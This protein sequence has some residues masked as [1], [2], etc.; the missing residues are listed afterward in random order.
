MQRAPDTEYIC[1]V[2][3]GRH[4]SLLCII[5]TCHRWFSCSRFAGYARTISAE[6]IC[7]VMWHEIDVNGNGGTGFFLLCI[8]AHRWTYMVAQCDASGRILATTA[9]ATIYGHRDLDRLSA[10]N[11]LFMLSYTPR[12][13]K[14]PLFC[15]SLQTK[16]N[17]AINQQFIISLI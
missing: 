6:C 15:G 10:V 2:I 12:G 4:S 13:C 11:W 14:W 3:Y 7:L 1:C 9:T 8:P 16:A 5:C 17:E